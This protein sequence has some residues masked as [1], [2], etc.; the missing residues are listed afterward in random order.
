MPAEV[1]KPDQEPITVSLHQ[2]ASITKAAIRSGGH[3][4]LLGPSGCGKTMIVKQSV[5]EIAA[6]GGM[7]YRVIERNPAMEDTI[8]NR[9]A[10][11]GIT[12]DNPEFI[13]IGEMRLIFDDGTPACADLIVVFLDDFTNAPEPVQKA[14]MPLLLNNE[15]ETRFVS[16]R[17]VRSNVVFIVA[18]NRRKD[19]SGVRGVLHAVT[20]RADCILEIRPVVDEWVG[21][22]VEHD[23]PWSV[24]GTVKWNPEIFCSEK[25]HTDMTKVGNPRNWAA[26]GK[27]V[28]DWRPAPEVEY[29]TYAGAVGQME[30]QEFLSFRD[31]MGSL[32]DTEMILLDPDGAPI[33]QDN[34]GAMWATCANLCR[35]GD[36]DNWDA[37]VRYTDRFRDREFAVFTV[38]A[39]A[40]AHEELCSTKTYLDWCH[41]NKEVR[42]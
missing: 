41:R 19:K 31:V 24:I 3:I 11:C 29:A 16:G 5:K 27:I 14:Y 39:V 32:P 23:I 12:T 13:P 2:A 34:P 20:G 35:V 37:I 9:G 25:A 42:Y 1:F 28:R 7:T 15:G 18:G 4:W 22:A 30:A 33:P 26:L 21:W 38:L 8:D 17:P 10:L 40:K 36:L 6:E